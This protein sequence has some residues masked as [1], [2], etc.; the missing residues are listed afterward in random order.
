MLHTKQQHRSTAMSII[1]RMDQYKAAIKTI[2]QRLNFLNDEAD[3][4]VREFFLREKEVKPLCDEIVDFIDN[5]LCDLHSVALTHYAIK[6]IKADPIN[7][8][9]QELS[10]IAKGVTM[11]ASIN[12]EKLRDKDFIKSLTGIIDTAGKF[13]ENTYG[14][15]TNELMNTQLADKLV[16][17][18]SF[19]CYVN[20][21]DKTSVVQRFTE[22]VKRTKVYSSLTIGASIDDLSKKFGDRNHY[23][24]HT[25][26]KMSGELLPTLVSISKLFDNIH[27]SYDD[28]ND[29]DD[30]VSA[31]NFDFSSKETFGSFTI[32]RQKN[33]I[34]I[35]ADHAVISTII[36]YCIGWSKKLKDLE[37]MR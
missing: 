17:A 16:G 32:V 3:P 1:A 35:Q 29:A 27:F 12:A 8:V 13:L 24:Y 10:A 37:A 23:T 2:V 28:A 31:D 26:T 4:L 20:M 5:A 19:K 9:E 22:A 34:L 6:G 36:E 11:R 18:I 15:G 25:R 21:N 7:G 30:Y 14:K 33:K